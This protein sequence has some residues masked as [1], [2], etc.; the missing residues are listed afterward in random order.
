LQGAAVRH[1]AQL[2]SLPV[3]LNP[4]FI[5]INEQLSTIA[6]PLVAGRAYTLY[7]GGEG[8]STNQLS[9][10]GISVTS[11]FISVN[12]A[13]LAQQDFGT[14]LPV[15]SFE[16]TI[17]PNTPTGDYTVR[18]N[19]NTG[20]VACLVGSL[21]IEGAETTTAAQTGFSIAPLD[22]T[23]SDGATLVAGGLVALNGAGFS[24]ES[25]APR[26]AQAD[27]S[28]LSSLAPRG[29]AGVNLIYSSGATAYVPLTEVNG[30][31]LGFQMPNNAEP[32]RVL[33]ELYWNG[34]KTE[35]AA[36]QVINRETF[37]SATGS[38]NMK[39]IESN[40][41]A[42]TPNSSTLD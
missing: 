24:V 38:G 19:S 40:R 39:T 27:T 2:S 36:V 25:L 4:S 7:L 35:S 41:L 26:A 31:R 23:G 33:V 10:T 37:L 16:I 14:S 13:S 5:G 9:A 20:E 17:S 42:P 22:A 3:L 11:P 6:V 30:A 34:Q 18:L 28:S 1:N 32:G 29:A 15:I 12:S 8:C 21:S